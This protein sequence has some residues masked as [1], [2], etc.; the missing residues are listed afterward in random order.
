MFFLS[1]PSVSWR[2]LGLSITIKA[3]ASPDTNGG[4]LSRHIRSANVGAVT[5][6]SWGIC[7]PLSN[8]PVRQLLLSLLALLEHYLK[9][10]ASIWPYAAELIKWL[11]N[12]ITT[13][14]VELRFS[15]SPS[16][17]KITFS[18]YFRPQDIFK[19]VRGNGIYNTKDLTML[20]MR[21]GEHNAG[22]CLQ[23]LVT[24]GFIDTSTIG[25]VVSKVVL[26]LSL[27]SSLSVLLPFVSSWSSCVNGSFRGNWGIFWERPTNSGCSVPQKLKTGLAIA[28]S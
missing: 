23:D 9:M 28:R 24:I 20:F 12:P 27:S 3:A 16:F 21:M 6:L 11:R 7:D 25:C 4:N 18:R 8:F 22:H 1:S 5:K 2:W 14:D 13:I 26:C 15:A 10:I 17:H 19:T